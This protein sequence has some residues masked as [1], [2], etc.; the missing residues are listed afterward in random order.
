M[1]RTRNIKNNIWGIAVIAIPMLLIQTGCSKKFLDVNP[2]GQQPN[3]LFWVTQDDANKAVN[4]MYSN[5]RGWTNVA[6]APIAVESMGSDDAEKGGGYA[7]DANFMT[8]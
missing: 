2:Q 4:A 8:D 5:L 7:G 1:K 6:F 3:A